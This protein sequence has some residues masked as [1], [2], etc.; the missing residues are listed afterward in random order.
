M[1]ELLRVEGLTAGYGDTT[2]RGVMDDEA[3]AAQ[4]RHDA[5]DALLA[6]VRRARG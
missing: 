2:G 5:L 6:A 1:A 3:R 4:A